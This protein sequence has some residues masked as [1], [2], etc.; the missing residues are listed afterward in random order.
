M[1]RPPRGRRGRRDR[2]WRRQA[3]IRIQRLA[4]TFGR[5]ID[6]KIAEWLD[7]RGGD[8][9]PPPPEPD[10]PVPRPASTANPAPDASPDRKPA[11]P[12]VVL[13]CR[14]GTTSLLRSR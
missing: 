9:S 2:P 4:G 14:G 5:D 7:Y 12:A 11:L 3:H 8:D 6:Q 1:A 10:P 13:P